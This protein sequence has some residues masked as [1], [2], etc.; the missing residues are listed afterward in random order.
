MGA[1]SA[2]NRERLLALDPPAG[3][4]RAEYERALAALFERRLDGW[5]RVRFVAAAAGGAISAL[6]CGS[7]ALS[8]PETTPSS[9][10]IVLGVMSA[11]G[12]TWFVVAWRLL[13]RG[14]VHLIADRRRVA[15]IV[16]A[17]ATLQALYFAW[18]AR[19]SFGWLAWTRPGAAPALFTS[20]VVLI[21]AATVFVVHHIRESELRSREQHLRAALGR[22]DD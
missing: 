1:E 18:A 8:E 6:V 20:L 5:E 19:G 17:F 11:M 12:V 22:F 3:A 13:R 9:T 4:L 16:L 14:S 15:S 2:A 10:R 7:L 21:V